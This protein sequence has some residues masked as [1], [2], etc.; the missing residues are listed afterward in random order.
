MV[1]TGW[2]Y[3]S[4]VKDMSSYLNLGLPNLVQIVNLLHPSSENVVHIVQ[5]TCSYYGIQQY[6]IQLSTNSMLNCMIHCD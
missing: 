6:T 1:Y 3:P 2:D 4:I 5:C